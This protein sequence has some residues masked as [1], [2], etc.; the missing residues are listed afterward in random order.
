MIT[1]RNQTIDNDDYGLMIGDFVDCMDT[2]LNKFH[3]KSAFQFVCAALCDELKS[4]N[5]VLTDLAERIED[6]LPL[7]SDKARSLDWMEVSDRFCQLKENLE[8]HPLYDD[9][10]VSSEEIEYNAVPILPQ[11]YPLFL[12]DQLQES[13]EIAD[14]IYNALSPVDEGILYVEY[15][16]VEMKF[17]ELN[18]WASQVKKIRRE[19]GTVSDSH[20]SEFYEKKITYYKK[21]IS[22][23]SPESIDMDGNYIYE[24]SLGR[25]LWHLESDEE[26]EKNFGKMLQSLFSLKHFCSL[27]NISLTFLAND[28]GEVVEG[29]TDTELEKLKQA[30]RQ[31]GLPEAIERTKAC[32]EYLSDGYTEDWIDGVWNRFLESEHACFVCNKLSA[33]VRSKKVVCQFVGELL[34]LSVLN[35]SA[36]DLSISLLNAMPEYKKGL[37]RDGQSTAR[38]SFAKYIREGFKDNPEL[39][40][41]MSANACISQDE[42]SANH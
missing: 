15:L 4:L 2:C 40:K 8:Q 11:G 24:E 32:V 38:Q 14:R 42:E 36:R 1:A 39:S 31:K 41:W 34:R 25:Y 23:A 5:E 33:D 6:S 30:T 37:S 13:A 35:A 27:K 21:V 7:R 3:V 16:H 18:T 9:T 28:I 20:R 29:N 10:L 26:G 22:S 17:Y 19:L 12:K